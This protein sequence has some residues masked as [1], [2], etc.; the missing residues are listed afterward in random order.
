MRLIN[1]GMILGELEFT[2]Y[3]AEDGCWLSTAEVT[4]DAENKPL[5]KST[6]KPANSARVE[7]HQ[8][9]KQG[10]SFVLLADPKI[11]IESRAH[12]M[13]KARGNV[14]NPDQGGAGIRCRFACGFTKWFM[15]S[16][17]G[18]QALEHDGRER[19]AQVFW[20]A[21]WRMI[22]AEPQRNARSANPAVRLLPPLPE[23]NRMLHK[24]LAAVTADVERLDFNTAIARMMEFTNFFTK[25]EVRPREVMEPFVLILSPFAP[26]IAE[27]LWQLLGHASTLAYETVAGSRSGVA[28]RKTRWKCRYK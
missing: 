26:H 3:K 27:E 25:A 17:G 18:D 15:R 23:Q 9:E 8:V 28:E 14:I 4:H 24:T 20:I 12:K 13:S 21:S 5:E 2:A 16:A 1:Q 7:P 10:D 6:R 11:R 19:R 22:V